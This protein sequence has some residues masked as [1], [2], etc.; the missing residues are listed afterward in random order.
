ML[1]TVTV[2]HCVSIIDVDTNENW[3]YRPSEIRQALKKLSE[4]EVLIGHNI[5]GYDLPAL[6]KLYGF[7]FKGKLLDTLIMSRLSNTNRPMHPKCPTTVWD[8]H[9]QKNKSV[10]NHTLMNLGYWAGVNKGDFGESAGWEVFTEEMLEYCT[11]D[12]KVNVAI[13][14]MLLKEL[15][16]FSDYSIELEMDIAGYVSSQQLAGWMFDLRAGYILQAEL[17]EKIFELEQEVLRTFKPLPK[18][19]REVQPRVKMS[20]GTVSSV[21]LKFLEDWESLI[22]VPE[23]VDGNLGVEYTSGSFTRIDWPE[24]NLGSRKQI[25]EQ[26]MF[27]GWEPTELTVTGH[28]IVDESVLENIKDKFPEAALLADFFLLNKKL[29]MVTGWLDNYNDTTQRI[30]GYVN[31]LGAVTGR[32]TH[33]SPNLAQVPSAKVDKE[34]HLIYG[35]EGQYGADCRRLFTVPKGYKLVGCDASGLELRC[36]AHYMNDA[37][38]TDLIL[39]GDIHTANQHAAGLA[40]RGQAKTFI[41]A[42][43]YGAGDAKIGSIVGGSSRQ[44]KALKKKFLDNTPALKALREGVLKA[45]ERG[46]LKG[47]DGRRVRVRSAHAALNTLLQSCGAII[48]KV[49][50]R[51]LVKS[52]QAEGLDVTFVGNI[53][54]E[55]QAQ[56]ADKDV[57]RYTELCGECFIKAGEELK[58]RIKIEGEAKVGMNWAETH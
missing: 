46:W 23:Y 51:I 42:F 54:D 45:A 9:Q 37:A 29:G 43:L 22:P 3:E 55:F 36:L 34:G 35:Y 56:V 16:G 53:H 49:A 5:I 58:I 12:V 21:G 44:G 48:M 2:V 14:F 57:Q 30:H 19:V 28:P 17:Q 41:Y 4:A 11:Q 38:Y 26:L 1:N 47:I 24:F 40:Q 25:G 8:E 13:F 18:G 15:Q 50:L 10:G 20:D 31:S 7:E 27:R 39:H 6:K 33:S 32:M 52:V